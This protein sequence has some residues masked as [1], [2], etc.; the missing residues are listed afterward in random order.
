VSSRVR[1]APSNHGEQYLVQLELQLVVALSEGCELTVQV[2]DRTLAGGMLLLV[3]SEGELEL[4]L[5]LLD[6][7]ETV[8]LSESLLKLL[9]HLGQLILTHE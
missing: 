7:R 4:R 9:R 6:A 5:R 1:D 8:C 3:G 2:G